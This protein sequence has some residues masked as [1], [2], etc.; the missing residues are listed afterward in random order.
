MTIKEIETS[1]NPRVGTTHNA[2]IR[3]GATNLAVIIRMILDFQ[4][5]LLLGVIGSILLGLG[6]ILGGIVVYDF[7][8][9]GQMTM[10]NT[11]TLAALLVIT[12]IQMISLGLVADMIKRKTKKRIPTNSTYY[13]E[14]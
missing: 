9:T 14:E 12:G 5:L 10:T 13:F 3:S 8:I 2:T 4:P 6:V 11:A 1:Y 7:S